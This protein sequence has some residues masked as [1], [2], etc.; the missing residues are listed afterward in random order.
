MMETET[1]CSWVPPV[2]RAPVMWAS[3]KIP[4]VIQHGLRTLAHCIPT[5]P[6]E[7][8]APCCPGSG[9]RVSAC[10]QALRRCVRHQKCL[11]WRGLAWKAN[12]CKMR[13]RESRT[14]AFVRP[15]I[16]PPLHGPSTHSLPR[17]PSLQRPV[18]PPSQS[19]CPPLC[20]FFSPHDFL[21]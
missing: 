10:V 4:F 19:K 11:P 12:T 20:H 5:C 21:R 18:T 6:P 17:T 9:G 7:K 3:L 16:C 8:L 2:P 14:A 1:C 13:F 15:T